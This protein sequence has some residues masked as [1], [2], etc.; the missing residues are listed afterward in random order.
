MRLSCEWSWVKVASEKRFSGGGGD[1]CP[2]SDEKND[3]RDGGR[4]IEVRCTQR[5]GGLRT[6]GVVANAV[7]S[8][9]L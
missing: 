4:D 2:N 6:T 8:C 9:V 5:R 7:L 3:G 1:D